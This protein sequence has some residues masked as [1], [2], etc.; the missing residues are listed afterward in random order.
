MSNGPALYGPS[1]GG[2]SAPGLYVHAESVQSQFFEIDPVTGYILQTNLFQAPDGYNRVLIEASARWT[3]H[4]NTASDTWIGSN[5]IIYV[6]PFPPIGADG[7]VGTENLLIPAGETGPQRSFTFAKTYTVNPA[8]YLY[9]EM[10]L[11]LAGPGAVLAVGPNENDTQ[12][13]LAVKWTFFNV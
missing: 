9:M 12:A 13:G 3:V 4:N 10:F 7:F 8:D 1:S 11:G 6:P 5:L 2:S